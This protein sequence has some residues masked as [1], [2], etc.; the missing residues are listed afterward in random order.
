MVAPRDPSFILFPEVQGMV[1]AIWAD[2]GL[3]YPPKV[4]PLP[5]QARKTIAT[6]NRLSIFLGERTPSWCLLHELAHA[7][8]ST[9][10][11]IS[12]GHSE[13]FI[14][15]YVKLLVKFLRLDSVELARSLMENSISMDAQ[16]RPLF[17]ES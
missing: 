13:Q 11:G 12:D 4:E 3:R 6:A 17:L 16:A 15:I 9:I 10:D 8:T 2:M 5:K 1:N 7:M 14:G